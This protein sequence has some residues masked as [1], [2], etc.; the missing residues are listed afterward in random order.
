MVTHVLDYARCA[1][2]AAVV[3]STFCPLV[4][5]SHTRLMICKYP[6]IILFLHCPHIRRNPMNPKHN[7]RRPNLRLPA[8]PR[9]AR[10]RRA[11]AA[12]RRLLAGRRGEAR[13]AWG[14]VVQRARRAT[15]TALLSAASHASPPEETQL[16]RLV[17]RPGR[18]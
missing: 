7:E 12:R 4:Y 9:P 8:I 15:T 13:Q 17:A 16:T 10:A 6:V 11:G 3:R 2:R 14:G 1:P 18:S 5:T